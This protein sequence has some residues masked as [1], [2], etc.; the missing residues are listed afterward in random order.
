MLLARFRQTA[1]TKHDLTGKV[2]SLIIVQTFI[3]RNIMFQ[4]GNTQ[5]ADTFD[6]FQVTLLF[7]DRAH[8]LA[9]FT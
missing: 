9:K 5:C 3:D 2:I 6:L 1:D 8:H 7:L 4:L